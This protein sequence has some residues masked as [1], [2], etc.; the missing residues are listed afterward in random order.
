MPNDRFEFAFV[1]KVLQHPVHRTIRRR[2]AL[3][4]V[5]GGVALGYRKVVELTARVVEKC[6]ARTRRQSI[7]RTVDELAPALQRHVRKPKAGKR[8]GEGFVETIEA[9]GIE[10]THRDVRRQRFRTHD[11]R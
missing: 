1:G 8:A 4:R 2:T 5:T 6:E 9:I 11:R 10:F 3:V 7:K